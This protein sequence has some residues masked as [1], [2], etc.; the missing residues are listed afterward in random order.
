M[1]RVIQDKVENALAEALLRNDVQPGM[2]VEIDADTFA[3]KPVK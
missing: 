1:R 2:K 3:L